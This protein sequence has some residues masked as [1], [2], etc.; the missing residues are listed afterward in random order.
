MLR[1][2]RGHPATSTAA[3]E[4][5][6]GKAGKNTAGRH[7]RVTL[8]DNLEPSDRAAVAKAS[9]KRSQNRTQP[10]EGGVDRGQA[11]KTK[12]K[13]QAAHQAAASAVEVADVG[14]TLKPADL[15]AA[16]GSNAPVADGL[17]VQHEDARGS[18]RQ[19]RGAAAQEETNA[20]K[21]QTKEQPQQPK[22]V[23]SGAMLLAVDEPNTTGM[24]T[25][26][27]GLIT[28]LPCCS[29]TLF[30]GRA[31]LGGFNLCKPATAQNI[32]SHS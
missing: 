23:T 31:S 24:S 25:V 16:I 22:G 13:V 10:K 21:M 11:G 6:S 32:A 20:D 29:G 28:G 27:H 8:Q 1:S 15:N 7:V 12:G 5:V 17:T 9:S 30:V 26:H 3:A 19:R 2:R 18:R 4:P 14:R